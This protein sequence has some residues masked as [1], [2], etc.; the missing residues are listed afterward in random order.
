[1]VVGFQ[2]TLTPVV[3]AARYIYIVP[4]WFTTAGLPPIVTFSKSDAIFF[5]LFGLAAI[6]VVNGIVPAHDPIA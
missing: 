3:G 1:L 2:I 4:L 5:K 6:T